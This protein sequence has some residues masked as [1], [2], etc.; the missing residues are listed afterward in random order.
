MAKGLNK[1]QV[2]HNLSS[3]WD[4]L[5]PKAK[6]DFIYSLLGHRLSLATIA[7]AIG[8]PL[9]AVK[10]AYKGDQTDTEP[11]TSH[12]PIEAMDPQV[13]KVS[14]IKAMYQLT[15]DDLLYE[16]RKL[17]GWH[18]YTVPEPGAGPNDPDWF[19]GLI[20]SDI[21]APFHDEKRFAQMIS[22]TKGKVDVCILAGDA[23]DYNNFSKYMKYGQEFS[24]KQEIKAVTAIFAIL[25]ES[26]P[27]VVFLPG[28]HDERTR[29]KYALSL[30]P[31]LYQAMLD[32][33]G[34]N[35]FD[36]SEIITEQFNNII[37]P[38]FPTEGFAEY[39]YIY[40]KYDIVMG[41][42]EKYSR[43]PNRAVGDFI[44][45]IMSKGIPLGLVKPPITAA[46]IG[47]THQGGKTWN[48]FKIIGIENGCLCMNPDYDGNAKLNGAPRPLVRGYTLFKTNKHTERTAHN[49]IQ[50]IELE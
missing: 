35:A 42:P 16:Y 49:D 31:P 38:K 29:K 37:V 20:I 12:L 11:D 13:Q 24:A 50:F 10:L 6:K 40:Q 15:F 27:E 23:G 19:Y 14:P 5:H 25:S 45:Y 1:E 43:I 36:F 9:D 2:I 33:H 39:K 21:H 18:E 30:E 3:D 32:F 4:S 48:D 7:T 8:Q 41:H 22:Q 34:K 28:N 46:V 17:I 44:Y 26:Y 47:H